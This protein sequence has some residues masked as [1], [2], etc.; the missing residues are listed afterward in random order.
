MCVVALPVVMLVG[1]DLHIAHV[2][3]VFRHGHFDELCRG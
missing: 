3:V 2:V 1:S